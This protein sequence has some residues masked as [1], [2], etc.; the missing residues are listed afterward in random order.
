MQRVLGR[1]GILQVA[2][3]GKISLKRGE[4]LLEMGGWGDGLRNQS[5]PPTLSSNGPPPKEDSQPSSRQEGSD[6]YA[7]DMNQKGKPLLIGVQERMGS[8]EGPETLHWRVF[9]FYS[10]ALLRSRSIM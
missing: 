8:E 6:V 7:V 2:R 10:L 3:T 5:R 4:Q 9:V 1:F